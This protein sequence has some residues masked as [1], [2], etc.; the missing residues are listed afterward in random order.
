MKSPHNQR[1]D[2]VAREL[3]EEFIN[4]YSTQRGVAAK[5]G[6]KAGEGKKQKKDRKKAKA[7]S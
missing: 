5:A 4:K 1:P 3:T 2:A 7:K 6:A